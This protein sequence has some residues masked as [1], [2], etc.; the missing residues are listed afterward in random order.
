[1]DLSVTKCNFKASIM[2]S[3]RNFFDAM[4][5]TN[6]SASVHYSE[7]GEE[8]MKLDGA[9]DITTINKNDVHLKFKEPLKANYYI[10]DSVYFC[11]IPDFE[12]FAYGNSR[13]ELYNEIIDY[14]IDSWHEIVECDEKELNSK[15]VEFRNY[16]TDKI[17]KV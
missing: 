16:L 13:E 11:D 1:M 17:E 6:Y 5:S 12:I 9:F 10:C 3:L 8:N 2:N 7:I 14:I 15:A 4:N